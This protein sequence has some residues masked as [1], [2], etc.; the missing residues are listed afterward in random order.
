MALS[1]MKKDGDTGG[2][3]HGTAGPVARSEGPWWIA[4]ASLTGVPLLTGQLAGPAF[5]QISEPGVRSALLVGAG[6]AGGILAL[7]WA[8]ARQ[9]RVQVTTG[10]R[11]MLWPALAAPLVLIQAFAIVWTTPAVR[12]VGLPGEWGW[13]L[14]IRLPWLGAVLSQRG[15][16]LVL[17]ATALVALVA[18]VVVLVGFPGFHTTGFAPGGGLGGSLSLLGPGAKSLIYPAHVLRAVYSQRWWDDVALAAAGTLLLAPW[19]WLGGRADARSQ[20]PTARHPGWWAASLVGAAWVFMALGT[21]QSAGLNPLVGGLMASV[22]GR[23][24]WLGWFAWVAG[25]TAAFGAAWA[26][27]A[28]PLVGPVRRVGPV[29]RMVGLAL[30]S[31]AAGLVAGVVLVPLTYLPGW[32]RAAVAPLFI[33]AEAGLLMVAYLG[34]P[35]LGALAVAALWGRTARRQTAAWLG[36]AWLAGW[37]ASLPGLQGFNRWSGGPFWHHLFAGLPAGYGLGFFWLTP[38]PGPPDGGLAAGV[39]MGALVSAGGIVLKRHSLGAPRSSA[40]RE[41]G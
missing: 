12:V 2:E 7:A 31:A 35:A 36:A 19:Q 30:P 23:M 15:R 14:A 10:S 41:R 6:L 38:V 34:A 17:P 4:V 8:G 13:G 11:P 40:P 37:A 20:G 3:R 25:L 9:C 22:P 18:W 39:G 26:R 16:R 33:N 28:E 24:R 27:A 21:Q 5:S 32:P 1:V 29:W